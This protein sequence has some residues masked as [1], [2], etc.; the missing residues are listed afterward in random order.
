[1]KVA[2]S[3]PTMTLDSALLKEQLRASGVR[4][5]ALCA[6]IGKPAGEFV[7]RLRHTIVSTDE[8]LVKA[9][10]DAGSN[11][12]EIALHMV[13]NYMEDR[14]GISN[15]QFSRPE[16]VPVSSSVTDGD[17]FTETVF[18]GY[19][20]ELTV[21]YESDWCDGCDCVVPRD[22]AHSCMTIFC[23]DKDAEV[24]RKIVEVL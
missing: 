23:D 9:M 5:T 13:K 22:Q 12:R 10:I 8:A 17:G 24:V 2:L 15:L 21:S 7:M 6:N 20:V 16:L 1:M 11:G 4:P 19:R 3:K 18:K 14:K